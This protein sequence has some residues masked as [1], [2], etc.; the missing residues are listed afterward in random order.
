MVFLNP[1]GNLGGAERVLL[2]VMSAVRDRWPSTASHLLCLTDGPLVSAARQLGV[3]TTVFPFPLTL[4]RLGDSQL[5]QGS[6]LT[7]LYVLGQVLAGVPALGLC[8]ERLR[9]Q[10]SLLRPDVIHS[11]G[12]KTHLL[13]NL[14]RPPRVPVVWHVHD[15]YGTRSLVR[16]L[17]PWLGGRTA[18]GLAI[19]AAVGRDVNSL[20]PRVPVTVVLNGVD[21]Q[22]FR[23]GPGDGAWLDHL[24]GLPPAPANVVRIGLVATYARWKGHGVFLEAF[25]QLRRNYS[26]RPLR[27]YVIGGPLYQTHGS[28]VTRDE[29][30]QLARQW[31][32]NDC[33]G[34]VAFQSDPSPVYRAL[35]VV[36]HASTQ[37]EP[38]G[39]TIVEA[40]ACGR[41]VVVSQAGGAAELFTHERDALG[42]PPDDAGALAGALE[43]LTGDVQLRERLGVEA[44]H[45][46]CVRF[47]QSRFARQIV[48]FYERLT[49][50]VRS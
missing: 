36:V 39:L 5:C 21:E 13:A 19:S 33:L 14:A 45:S 42:V 49:S 26:G 48:A 34:L 16:R 3:T 50:A 6:T 11:N 47:S 43:R 25:G 44:R 12:I 7:R 32:V 20:L 4:G 41:A 17:L 31:H 35:D 22:T 28:Q 30:Q 9:R 15:F 38:F 37:P 8:A 27:A 40:M 46:V 23:P 2:H 24:A 10:L 18:A 1:T 29:L